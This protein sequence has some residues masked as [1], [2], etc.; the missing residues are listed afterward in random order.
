MHDLQSMYELQHITTA[1][2]Y[3]LHVPTQSVPTKAAEGGSCGVLGLLT[4][5]RGWEWGPR[6][7]EGRW[8]EQAHAQH[9]KGV[10]PKH[11]A[12]GRNAGRW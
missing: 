8:Q 1:P 9:R 3:E 10:Q 4:F 5:R 12:T 2:M 7:H 6:R 11:L